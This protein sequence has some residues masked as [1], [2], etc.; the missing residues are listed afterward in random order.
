MDINFSYLWGDSDDI[1]FFTKKSYYSKH[2]NVYDRL[3]VTPYGW[4]Q[5]GDDLSDIDK[6]A[7]LHA[8][9]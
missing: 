1:S 9:A 3:Y 5:V 2:L 8:I 4:M 6:V 7:S